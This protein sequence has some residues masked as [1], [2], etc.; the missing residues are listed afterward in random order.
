MDVSVYIA[1]AIQSACLWR[2]IL[3]L[4]E[5]TL[6]NTSQSE[7]WR[8][9]CTRG[10]LYLKWVHEITEKEAPWECLVYKLINITGNYYTLKNLASRIWRFTQDC[11]KIWLHINLFRSLTDS[12]HRQ[13]FLITYIGISLSPLALFDELKSHLMLHG[14]FTFMESIM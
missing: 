14:K 10:F 9:K 11:F 13:T 7:W 2:Q 5:Q 4:S 3:A 8:Q 12:L 1:L 6:L